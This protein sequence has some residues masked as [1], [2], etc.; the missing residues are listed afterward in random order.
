MSSNLPS[1][2][3]AEGPTRERA[4]NVCLS[5]RRKKKKCDKALPKCLHCQRLR[6]QC[7][8]EDAADSVPV[9]EEFRQLRKRL[10][11]FEEML[12][13]GASR[14]PRST[15]SAADPDPP[16]VE[17]QLGPIEYEADFISR[18]DALAS[19]LNVGE[20][21][22]QLLQSHPGEI[23]R[24][25]SLYFDNV[26]KWI[27]IMS[28]KLFYSKMTDFSKTKR[29]DFAILLLSIL[30][31]IHCPATGTA[32][33]PLYKATRSIFWSVNA[34]ID[35]SLEM[36]QAGLLLSCYEYGF[37]MYK[38]CYKTI[39]TCA[40]MGH[41]MDLQ[42]EKPPS[43][44]L[45]YSD[46]WIRVAERCNV[47]W[48]STMLHDATFSKPFAIHQASMSQHL[49]FEAFDLDP[50]YSRLGDA[51]LTQDE[52][53]G[54][55]GYQAKAWCLFDRTVSFRHSIATAH[56][57]EH[58]GDEKYQL[59]IELQQL[60]RILVERSGGA[61]C[62]YCEP[63]AITL[64]RHP[65]LTADDLCKGDIKGFPPSCR[66]ASAL[67]VKT[68]VR[69]VVDVADTINNHYRKINIISFPPTY[70]HVIYRAT[71]ELI[72]F[73]DDMDEAEWTAALETLRE[74]TWN[75]GR[76]WQAAAKH[77][78]A[79]DNVLSDLMS[80]SPS[81]FNYFQPIQNDPCLVALLSK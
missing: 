64:V 62:G 69:M 57:P 47:W 45:R 59:D 40:R 53:P 50:S 73:R 72:S 42:D 23:Y 56:A 58:L 39:G 7:V 31:S 48:A 70:C 77:L 19:K 80:D 79:V 28:Q 32:P 14:V 63:S 24:A 30:L 5:C 49:P 10:K 68:I 11:L 27:P 52:E 61:M 71:L 34:T 38:E 43:D 41:W 54:V 6:I 44:H 55:F 76:R 18:L 33:E 51:V 65:P 67:V 37:G 46:E 1:P 15:P 74:A 20:E 25:L 36:I 26:H 66:V 75:Y 35:A 4:D 81:T 13:P 9:I 21:V 3:S 16:E 2:E 22:Y 78:Q 29:P 60:M 12:V 8:Y 17:S